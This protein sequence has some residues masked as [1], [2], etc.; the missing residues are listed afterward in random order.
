MGYQIALSPAAHRDLR[1]IVRYISLD[2][3]ERAVAFGQFL[4]GSIKRLADFPELG[5]IVPEF[6]DPELRE[7]VV[8]SWRIIYRLNHED[9]RIDIARFWHGARGTPEIRDF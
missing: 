1:D 4:L 2:S 3:P 8:R 9:C 6:D 5:R 7:I